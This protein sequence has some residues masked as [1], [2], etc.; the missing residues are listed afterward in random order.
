M[1][2]VLLPLGSKPNESLPEVSCRIPPSAVLRQRSPLPCHVSGLNLWDLGEPGVSCDGS[3]LAA[4]GKEATEYFAKK[5][6]FLSQWCWRC[7]GPLDAAS[8][9][10]R[11]AQVDC[12]SCWSCPQASQQNLPQ[13]PHP[14]TLVGW[15]HPLA[16]GTEPPNF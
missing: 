4:L 2:T 15:S 12:G 5:M 3:C 1:F 8:V 7:W 11:C 16:A 6:I 9:P 14:R 13:V 10:Q